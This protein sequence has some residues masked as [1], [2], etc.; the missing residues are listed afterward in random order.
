MILPDEG[1][2]GPVQTRCRYGRAPKEVNRGTE[3]HRR[4]Y[5]VRSERRLN[6]RS[7]TEGKA[8]VL[9]RPVQMMPSQ[10]HALR[11][12]SLS[13]AVASAGRFE[14][15]AMTTGSVRRL[16]SERQPMGERPLPCS[17][18]RSSRYARQKYAC[19]AWSEGV[20]AAAGQRLICRGQLF[21]RRILMC[22]SSLA[23]HAR[24]CCLTGLRRRSC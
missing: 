20:W 18:P 6:G 1:W 19:L 10:S 17:W 2:S 9:V 11:G 22:P 21:V 16:S 8:A 23:A 3:E 14:A 4:R 5:I 12:P 24:A 15:A 13:P 7:P